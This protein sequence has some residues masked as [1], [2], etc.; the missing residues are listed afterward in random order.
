MAL[1]ICNCGAKFDDPGRDEYAGD[2]WPC[3]P[4]CGN[5]DFEPAYQC[6]CCGEDFLYEDVVDGIICPECLEGEATTEDYRD[7]AHDP[8]VQECFAEWLAERYSEVWKER[9]L[10][11]YRKEGT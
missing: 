4:E 7:F 5:P 1:Y 2:T 10:K 11:R 3:C 9:R 6:M 8:Q